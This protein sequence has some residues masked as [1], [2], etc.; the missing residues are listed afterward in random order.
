MTFTFDGTNDN[1]ISVPVKGNLRFE[2]P[3][4]R[5]S[6]NRL[7]AVHPTGYTPGCL[8]LIK[9]TNGVFVLSVVA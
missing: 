2:S 1:D 8:T 3:K 7:H 9:A 6:R 4:Q 5:S